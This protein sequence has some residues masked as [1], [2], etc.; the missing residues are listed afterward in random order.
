MIFPAAMLQTQLMDTVVSNNALFVFD[1][2]MIQ[3]FITHTTTHA[4]CGHCRCFCI[5]FGRD[6]IQKVGSCNIQYKM[7]VYTFSTKNNI[8]V[9]ITHIPDSSLLQAMLIT[10]ASLDALKTQET[11]VT[12]V[13]YVIAL[14]VPSMILDVVLSD[15]LVTDVCEV[16][17]E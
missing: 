4:F 1:I 16:I 7:T 10:L 12:L 15:S 3:F 13:V 9:F 8:F 2:I 17:A 5:E 6:K 11:S 14:Y